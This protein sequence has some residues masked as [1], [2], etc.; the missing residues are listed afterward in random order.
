MSDDVFLHS[1]HLYIMG[2]EAACSYLMSRGMLLE[3]KF[4]RQDLCTYFSCPA[5]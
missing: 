1:S 3:E 2:T 5:D 4:L